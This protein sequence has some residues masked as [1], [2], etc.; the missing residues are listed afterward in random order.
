MPISFNPSYATEYTTEFVDLTEAS[1]LIRENLSRRTKYKVLLTENIMRKGKAPNDTLKREWTFDSEDDAMQF[2]D[3]FD[4][5]K[6]A[7]NKGYR[8]ELCDDVYLSLKA[9]SCG[10]CEIIIDSKEYIVP[11]K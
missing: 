7:Q 1:N 5:R 3:G 2:F 6:E 8:K 9:K 4:L 10:W 11:M